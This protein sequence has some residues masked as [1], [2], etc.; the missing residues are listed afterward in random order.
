[1]EDRKEIIYEFLDQFNDFTESDRQNGYSR[2][3]RPNWHFVQM[4][5]WFNPPFSDTNTSMPVPSATMVLTREGKI[6]VENVYTGLFFDLDE[7]LGSSIDNC[8]SSIKNYYLLT[9]L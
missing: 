8:I 9:T 5:F 2:V 3:Y 1:M 4:Q 6:M 7:C